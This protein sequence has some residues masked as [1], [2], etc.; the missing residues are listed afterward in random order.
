VQGALTTGALLLFGVPGALALGVLAALLTF[1]PVVG[2][3][4]VTVGA[5]IYLLA[6]QRWAAAAGMVVAAVVIGVSD[7]V[8]RPWVQSA[9]SP[10]HPLLVL[11]SIFGGLRVFGVAG[12]FLGPVVAALAVWALRVYAAEV[13][14]S[15][16]VSG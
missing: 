13:A 6:V 4:P 11:L 16:H 1:V 7:N 3:A 5:V 15:R 10:L 14:E 9:S 12:V 8:V 2:T